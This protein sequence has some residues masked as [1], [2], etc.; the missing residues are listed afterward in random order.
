MKE[1]TKT[2][3]RAQAIHDTQADIN[4]ASKIGLGLI[5]SFAGLVGA[6]GLACLAGALSTQGIGA[7]VKGFLTAVTG[8]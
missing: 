4:Q 1:R 3:T 8:M 6:W 5:L 2:I 7:V